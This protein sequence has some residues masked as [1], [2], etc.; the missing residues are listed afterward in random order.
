MA[1]F[2]EKCPF[3]NHKIDCMESWDYRTQ[4]IVC[5]KNC[6]RNV[7]VCVYSEP[8]FETSKPACLMC[9]KTLKASEFDY[10]AACKNK[11]SAHA[12]VGG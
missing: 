11:L 4:F 1:G 3:C 9:S 7:L 5:C 12:P 2:D 8:S 6:E 10:C